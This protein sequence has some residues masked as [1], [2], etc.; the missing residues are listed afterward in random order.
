MKLQMFLDNI[1]TSKVK[2]SD[3]VKPTEDK[4]MQRYNNDILHPIGGAEN[5]QVRREN[6]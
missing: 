3:L 2:I 1:F 4:K 6:K 5:A